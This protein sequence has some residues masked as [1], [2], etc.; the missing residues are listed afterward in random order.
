MEEKMII[1]LSR[2]QLEYLVELFDQCDGSLNEEEEE[3]FEVLVLALDECG[4]DSG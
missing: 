1:E 2:N 4:D 3:I